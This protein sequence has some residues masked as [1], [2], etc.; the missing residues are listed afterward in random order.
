MTTK[1]AL[2][3]RINDLEEALA[4]KDDLI[5]EYRREAIT[6]M[7]H[8]VEQQK[9]INERNDLLS[10]ISH[11]LHDNPDIEE[12]F[13]EWEDEERQLYELLMES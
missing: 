7:D 1:I 13:G 2:K 6:M 4:Y 9:K 12:R 5:E 10:K 11:F 8:I 3:K